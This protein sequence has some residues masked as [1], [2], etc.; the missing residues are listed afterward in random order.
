MTGSTDAPAT[1]MGQRGSC[2]CRRADG[3][4]LEPIR[5]G[6]VVD[7]DRNVGRQSRGGGRRTGTVNLAVV[8]ILMQLPHL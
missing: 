3:I 5:A 1:E 8:G 2:D 4:K 6:Y 7:S